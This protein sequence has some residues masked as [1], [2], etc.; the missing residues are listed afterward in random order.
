METD[1]KH[2]GEIIRRL[3]ESSTAALVSCI[4][5]W[6]EW[7]QV[8]FLGARGVTGAHPSL[9]EMWVEILGAAVV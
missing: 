4:L 5:E 3:P 2:R 1:V 7:P 8:L 6:G 9:L